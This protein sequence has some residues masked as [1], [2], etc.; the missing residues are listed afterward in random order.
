MLR[1]LPAIVM[2]AFSFNAQSQQA[3]IKYA[4]KMYDNKGYYY[5]SE[6]YEDALARKADSSVVAAKIADSYD[7]MGNI[8]KATDWY[9]YINRKGELDQ[10]QY[11]RLALLERQMSNYDESQKLLAEFSSKYGANDVASNITE[12]SVSIADLQNKKWFALKPRLAINTPAS[13]IGVSYFDCEDEILISSSKR[14]QKVVAHVHSWTGDYYY[15]VYRAS[16]D[17]NGDI[18]SKMKPLKEIDK[19][20]NDGPISYNKEAGI[21]YFT[22]NAEFS[23]IDDSRKSSFLKIYKAKLVNDKFKDVEEIGVNGEDFST[24]HPSVSKD[25]KRLYFASDRPGG[26][27]GMDIYYVNLDSEGNTSGS[28]INLEKINTSENDMFPYYNSEE[29]LLFFASE[30]HFGLGGLDVFVSRVDKNGQAKDV[31]NLGAPINSPYDDF[32][33]INNGAQTNGFFVSNRPGGAGLDDIYAFDQTYVI[34]NRAVIKGNLLDLL[35]NEKIDD[36]TIYIAD[37][38][39]NVLDS[40]QSNTDGTFSISIPETINDDFKL[41]GKKDGYV[42]EL[43]TVTYDSNKSEYAQ[44]LKLM[45]VLEYYFAGTITDKATGEP[46]EDVKVVVYD[47]NNNAVFV[48]ELTAVDGGF[49]TDNLPYEYKDNISYRFTLEKDGY[50]TKSLDYG[51]ILDQKEEILVSSFLDFGLTEI[52]VGKTDLSDVIEIK[53]I[54]FDL[55][56]FNIRP[57]A[58]IELDKVVAVMQD[59]PRMVIELR[60]YTDSRGSA[61]YNRTLSDRRAKSSAQYIISRGIAKDRIAG[62]GYGSTN[63]KYT[64]AEINKAATDEEK[65]AMHEKNRRTEFIVVR[66]K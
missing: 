47:N 64:D 50:V 40:V 28:P 18:S 56:K 59:N 7:K 58:A 35:T 12:S 66:M 1:I 43:A 5:A 33:F 19:K 16:V 60:S 32:S 38:N 63:P 13:E 30:G 52:E 57:D 25:G 53:P 31:E 23:A 29:G 11:I 39:G 49:K 45:P 34:R 44:D 10:S 14:R 46:L 21:I 6:A 55:N 17:Q 61:A 54:F 20:Y 24:A 41:I 9:Q 8:K 3:R 37:N 4:D 15:N 36:G 2:V 62:K 26:K 42:E 65:E 51:A 27:G 48:E 22:R